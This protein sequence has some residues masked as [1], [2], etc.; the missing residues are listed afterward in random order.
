MNSREVITIICFI[1]F[2]PGGQCHI[3]VS[4]YII[5]S[6]FNLILLYYLILGSAHKW[7]RHLRGW[8]WLGRDE[9]GGV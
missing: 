9:G 6:Y 1:I 4:N 3:I 2:V 8:R 7:R 5:V